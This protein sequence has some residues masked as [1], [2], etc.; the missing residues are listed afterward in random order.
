MTNFTFWHSTNPV[1]FRELLLSEIPHPARFFV[2]LNIAT[3][4]VNGAGIPPRIPS[5]LEQVFESGP[6]QK[7]RFDLFQMRT[8]NSL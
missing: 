7:E 3:A 8:G 5:A 1:L 2:N 6:H 4:Y